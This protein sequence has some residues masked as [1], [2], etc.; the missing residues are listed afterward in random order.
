MTDKE[1]WSYMCDLTSAL[2]V[3]TSSNGSFVLPRAVPYIYAEMCNG[4]IK[5]HDGFS[6]DQEPFR[7]FGSRHGRYFERQAWP[8]VEKILEDSDKLEPRVRDALHGLLEAEVRGEYCGPEYV[9]T[10][11]CSLLHILNGRI[12][13]ASRGTF[14]I[15]VPLLRRVD[16]FMER[17][18]KAERDNVDDLAVAMREYLHVDL[19]FIREE[20]SRCWF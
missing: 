6:E 20:E 4:V 19:D 15:T 17:L 3:R 5:Y 14:E 11:N 9:V 2:L 1:L 12:P 18:P 16:E 8:V 13:T 7:Y 10:A